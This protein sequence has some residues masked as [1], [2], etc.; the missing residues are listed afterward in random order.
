MKKTLS[1]MATIVLYL[2]MGNTTFAFLG[3][4]PKIHPNHIS[5][6]LVG[7]AVQ[8]WTFQ[9]GAPCRV[10]ILDGRGL[11]MLTVN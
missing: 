3:S 1:L 2:C 7:Q 8:S 10:N 9:D 5:K 11:K 6:D 4:P